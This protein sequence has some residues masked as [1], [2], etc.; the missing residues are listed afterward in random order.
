MVKLENGKIVKTVEP[1]GESKMVNVKNRQVRKSIRMEMAK[2]L[3]AL[4]GKIGKW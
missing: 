2:L 4:N 3:S 1:V